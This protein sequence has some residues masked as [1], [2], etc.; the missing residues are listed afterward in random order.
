MQIDGFKLA[1]FDLDGTLLGED[2]R[3]SEEN[4]VALSKL[5]GA[6]VRVGLATGR[7]LR[8]ASPY[9]E[10][11]GA[12]GPLI[13]FNG[14]RV[15]DGDKKKFVFGADL[16]REDALA[17]LEIA[18]Y[19]PDSHVNLYVD[20]EIYISERSE[21]SIASEIKDGVPHTVVGDLWSWL[22]SGEADPIK[23]MLI[24]EPENLEVF[25]R[26]FLERT[27][28]STNLIHSERTY[29]ELT[30]RGVNKGTALEALLG[31]YGLRREEVI[32]FGDNLNDVELLSLSGLGVAMENALPEVKAV[33]G[34]VIGSHN[35][36]AIQRF[37]EEKFFGGARP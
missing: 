26:N 2:R 16:T 5:M 9:A 15:W 34:K 18:R 25:A 10:A 8:S 27:S 30:R 13:L 12:N 31:I 28:G 37:L 14:A 3:V 32:A 21:L 1:L 11:V 36:N 20:E 22:S 7:T 17:A 23:L 4:R 35:G 6:G 19:V 29:L 33:A 24:S